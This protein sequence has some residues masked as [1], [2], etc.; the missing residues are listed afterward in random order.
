MAP[1]DSF[2]QKHI[3]I[4]KIHYPGV[5]QLKDHVKNTFSRNFGK[6]YHGPIKGMCTDRYGSYC[7]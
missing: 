5:L 6:Y 1:S 2:T 3:P 4:P 7:I